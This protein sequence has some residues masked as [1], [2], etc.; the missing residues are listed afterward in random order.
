MS[1]CWWGFEGGA[2][3]L[4]PRNLVGCRDI[5]LWKT[6]YCGCSWYQYVVRSF[7]CPSCYQKKASDL[8]LQSNWELLNRGKQVTKVR[9]GANCDTKREW[10]P[11]ILQQSC[12]CWKWE[13]LSN[14]PS[15]LR[16]KGKHLI[17]S[18]E[19]SSEAIKEHPNAILHSCQSTICSIIIIQAQGV[20][21]L[22]T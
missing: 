1:P 22:V 18:W 17:R 19:V 11:R 7:F 12:Q 14:M 13:A 5:S 3:S 20:L 6:Q 21:Y 4:H 15:V 10:W 2:A 8:V 9:K 16:V